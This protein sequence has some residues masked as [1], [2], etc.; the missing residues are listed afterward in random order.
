MNYIRAA[1]H[2]RVEELE[3]PF[4]LLGGNPVFSRSHAILDA[5]LKAKKEDG[6][7]P[8]MKHKEEICVEDR[9]LLEDY[10]EDVIS[11]NNPN[12]LTIYVW[13]HMIILPSARETAD[14]DAKI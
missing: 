14:E 4:N 2:R 10:F 8:T 1:I 3:R 9:K 6:L 7:E 11:F 5:T 13:Y 12:K